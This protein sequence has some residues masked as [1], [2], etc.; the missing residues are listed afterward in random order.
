MKTR[1]R[2]FVLVLKLYRACL[3]HK[4]W[5]LYPLLIHMFVLSLGAEID[6]HDSINISIFP[7]IYIKESLK[8]D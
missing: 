5:G 3:S 6:F 2:V 8:F 7:D 4:K 1:Y